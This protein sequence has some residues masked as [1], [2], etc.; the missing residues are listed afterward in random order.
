MKIEFDSIKN[1]WNIENR[2]LGFNQAINLDWENAHIIEDTRKDYPEPRFVA[3]AYLKQRLHIICFTPVTGGI[4]V[5]SFR[6][7]NKREI[8][9]YEKI[10]I[11]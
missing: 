5:I 9:F 10:T 1:Q 11:K 6:K 8:K 7:A 2:Q 4:R 3:T